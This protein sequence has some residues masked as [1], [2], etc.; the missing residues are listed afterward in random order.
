MF[1]IVT[2]LPHGNP[3]ANANKAMDHFFAFGP[4]AKDAPSPRLHA[5]RCLPGDV[6][7]A[8]GEALARHGLMPGKG[9]LE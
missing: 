4:Q 8:T 2:G 9:Y 6:I 7:R 5:G 1:G 3:F